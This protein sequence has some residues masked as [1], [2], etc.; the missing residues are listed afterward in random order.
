[1]GLERPYKVF[2]R[3]YFNIAHVAV[4]PQDIREIDKTPEPTE[5]VPEPTKVIVKELSFELNLYPYVDYEKRV[6]SPEDS[7]IGTAG[8][9]I[10]GI[11]MNA[12]QIKRFLDLIYECVE[13]NPFFVVG[14][15]K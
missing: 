7:K 13:D 15:K 2:D 9:P 11:K 14:V 8:V 10:P 4:N 12:D 5:E 1:M 6:A 3:A